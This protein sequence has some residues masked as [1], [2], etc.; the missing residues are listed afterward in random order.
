[1][2]N[3]YVITVYSYMMYKIQY[4][5]DEMLKMSSNIKKNEYLDHTGVS[6]HGVYDVV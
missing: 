1:V 3:I 6:E 4:F 5:V 2:H